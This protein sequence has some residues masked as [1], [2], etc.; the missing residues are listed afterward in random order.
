MRGGERWRRQKDKVRI[1]DKRY[2]AYR[3]AGK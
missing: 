2:L 1:K 3:Q